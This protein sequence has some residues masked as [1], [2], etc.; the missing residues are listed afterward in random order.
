M[1]V[2]HNKCYFEWFEIGRTEY[3]RKKRIPYKDIEARGHYL[4]VVEA[5]CRYKKTLRYDEKF[6]IRVSLQELT[7]KKA[8]F[9][10]E[11]MTRKERKPIA[12]GYTVH[13]S[14]DVN[15][16]VCPLPSDIREKLKK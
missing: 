16:K 11:L 3:C 1:G 2:A 13:I 12:S 4:V 8:I 10:Y 15:A 5:F 6:V 9:S 7:P 14:T